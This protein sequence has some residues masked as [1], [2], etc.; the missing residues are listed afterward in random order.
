MVVL[1]DDLAGVLDVAL[2]QLGDVHEALNALQDLNEGP[3]RN[4]LGGTTV[5]DVALLVALEDTLPRIGLGLLKTKRNA[6]A[7][8]VDVEHLDLDLLADFEEL[9]RVVDVAPRQ[10]RDVDQAIDAVEV[11][12]RA[13]IDDVRHDARDGLT[14]CEV[15]EDALANLTALLLEHGAARQH[16]VVARAVELDHLAAQL[17]AAEL[18]EIL[19]PA[20]IDQRGGQEAADAEIDDQA[21]LDDLNDRAVDGLAGLGGGLNALPRLLKAGALL[22]QD[23]AAILVFLLHDQGVDLFAHLDLVTGVDGTADAQLGDGNDTLALVADV[24]QDLVL[25]DAHDLAGHNVALGE[26]RD[27]RVVVRH[28]LAV[29]FDPDTRVCGD[30]LFFGHAHR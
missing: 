17:L 15:V 2:G 4:H 6:L 3:E 10:L 24:D 29:D 7:V 18:L 5:H 8:A 22:R 21:A 11:D 16:D 1:R 27:R 19:D 14:R 26:L 13:E 28:H 9:G 12:K 20:D 25:V 23:Q 30:H